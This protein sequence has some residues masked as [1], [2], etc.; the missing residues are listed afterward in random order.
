MN[1]DQAATAPGVDRALPL[2]PTSLFEAN[3]QDLFA[4][5]A[6][7]LGPALAEDI[8]AETF[9]SAIEGAGRFDAAM[10]N[11]RAWL[12]GIASNLIR[13]HWRTEQRRLA[14]LVRSDGYP[15]GYTDD[16]E[17][18]DGKVDTRHRVQLRPEVTPLNADQFAS[19]RDRTL[20]TIVVADTEGR[21]TINLNAFP[22]RQRK[23]TGLR[24]AAAVLVIT[25]IAVG[26]SQLRRSKQAGPSI[27]VVPLP[28]ATSSGPAATVV[29][30][31]VGS[32]EN[33]LLV[34]TD[35]RRGIDANDSDFGGIGSEDIGTRSDTML[36]LRFDPKSQQGVLVSLPRDLQVTIADTGQAG[37]LNSAIEREDHSVGVT[38]LIRTVQNLGI[39]INHY[40]EI[41]M[42][43]FK[44]LID[45]LGGIRL[46]FD[47][48]V[49]DVHTGLDVP[50][51]ECITLNGVQARQYVRSRYLEFFAQGSWHD[52][53]SSDLG[54]MA[55]Q[56][57]FLKRSIDQ[58]LAR[59]ATD[60]TSLSRLID[61]A[62]ASLKVDSQI[63]LRKLAA[64]VRSVAASSIRSSTL[65]IAVV[66]DDGR[67]VMDTEKAAPVLAELQGQGVADPKPVTEP[68]TT[69]VTTA[70]G[71]PLV[72]VS[73]C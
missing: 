50:K 63:D 7:R 49:R 67:L 57:D 17:R 47:Y 34:G 48:P 42:S 55:R 1:Q 64:T 11:E 30:I 4:Y 70:F 35:S 18:V 36:V 29:P 54:R 12:F 44:N 73:D 13:R 51:A 9:R 3:G 21:M 20:S 24:I 60:P 52:D 45:A 32:A 69:D 56:Q 68:V 71:K 33:Y 41:D 65:P 58:T 53:E 19:L 14:A 25:G 31:A 62:T 26:G 22:E 5:A 59:I 38:N 46:R 37:G 66:N 61:A 8:V 23:A 28:P 16:F 6:R 39:P 72:P 40:I 2:N 27:H 15:I 10:G 43:G